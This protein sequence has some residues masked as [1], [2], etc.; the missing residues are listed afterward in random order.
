MTSCVIQVTSD[1]AYRL[2]AQHYLWKDLLGF[3]VHPDIPTQASGL[4][5]AD[6]ATGNGYGCHELKFCIGMTAHRMDW[7]SASGFMIAPATCRRLQNCM[8]SISV[9][10]RSAPGPGCRRISTCI[11]GIYLK[12][13][14]RNYKA[15]SMWSTS[16]ISWSWSRTTIHAWCSRICSSF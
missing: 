8:A 16:D 4:R 14:R 1:I 10:T 11:R 15:T 5:V 3:L 13:L 9:S 7:L 12:S 6:I 2:T